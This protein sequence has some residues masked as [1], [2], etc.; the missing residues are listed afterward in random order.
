MFALVARKEEQGERGRG[1]SVFAADE[2]LASTEADA[3]ALLIPRSACKLSKNDTWHQEMEKQSQ[4]DLI[5]PVGKP[6]GV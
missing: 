5:K 4:S 3:V 1:I 6:V 2:V